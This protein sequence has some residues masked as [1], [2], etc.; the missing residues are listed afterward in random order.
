MQNAG[1][2]FKKNVITLVANKIDLKSKV[3]LNYTI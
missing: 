2:D 3:K 1:I